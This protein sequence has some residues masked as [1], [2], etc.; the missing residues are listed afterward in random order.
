MKSLRQILTECTEPQLEQIARLWGLGDT[1]DKRWSQQR[2]RLEQGMRDDI[3]TRF[4]WEHL[5]EDERQ[6][7][8]N[9]LG[10]SSRNW[11]VRDDL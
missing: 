5:G 2:M 8:Y 3:S 4:V 11:T 9:I 10:P 7:L 1:S 6:V